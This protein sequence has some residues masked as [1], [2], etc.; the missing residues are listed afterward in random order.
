MEVLTSIVEIAKS[1]VLPVCIGLI[2]AQ[3]TLRAGRQQI[4]AQ[5]VERI[6]TRD[7][8]RQKRRESHEAAA[9]AI[10]GETIE[11]ISDS[12]DQYTE[13]VRNRKTATTASVTRSLFRL[14]TRCSADHLADTCRSYVEDAARA[15]DPAHAVE[16]M[17]D[18]RRRLLGWHIG[19]LTLDDAERLIREGNDEILEHLASHQSRAMVPD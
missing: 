7:E 14:S 19:H 16:A 9:V 8:E 15:P 6:E 12:I 1:V 11:S 2:T 10:R 13:E 4:K 18:I 17:I 3:V 5:T